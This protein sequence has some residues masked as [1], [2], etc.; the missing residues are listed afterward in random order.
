MPEGSA[1][2]PSGGLVWELPSPFAI[3]RIVEAA[4]VDRLG[5]VNNAV[6]LAWCES[7]A[8]EHADHVGTGWDAWQRLDR[9][10]AVHAVRLQYLAPAFAADEVRAANWIVRN[11]GRLRATRRFQ[12]QRTSD[13]RQLLQ[14]EIDYVCIEISSGKPRRMPSEF[15][16]AYA[17]LPD[18]AAAWEARPT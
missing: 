15:L 8:W 18:V 10:M 1:G 6:Y 5:H 3:S 7:V 2:P 12:I 17:V 4:E 16:S 14:G 13:G 9:A 11:D